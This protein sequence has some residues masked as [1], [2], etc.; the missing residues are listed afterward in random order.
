MAVVGAI[1]GQALKDKMLSM[2]SVVQMMLP[3]QKQ[4]N[5]WTLLLLTKAMM[6]GANEFQLTIFT[7]MVLLPT[8]DVFKI[9]W[10]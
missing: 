2:W 10:C 4:T 6:G 9:H 3:D 1:M 7:T 5:C 8:A